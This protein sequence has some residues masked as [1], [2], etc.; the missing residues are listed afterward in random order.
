MS[1]HQNGSKMETEVTQGQADNTEPTGTTDAA[2]AGDEGQS[3]SPDRTT[4]SGPDQGAQGESFFDPKSIE[5]DPNLVA[6]YKGMQGTFSKKMDGIR[7]NQ[8][9]IDAYNQYIADPMGTVR[10]I[11]AQNGMTLVNGQP[12][13]TG[14]EE[15]SP[16]SWADVVSHVTDQVRAE[17]TQQYEPLVGEVKNLKQQNIEQYLDNKYSDW[18]TYESEMIG[19]LQAH[20]SMAHDPDKLYQMSLPPEVLEAR[21]TERAL[22]KLKGSTD[23]AM[24][25][26][27]K[28]ATQTTSD[29]PTGSLS[30]DDAVKFA[31]GQLASQGIT[32]PVGS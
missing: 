1:R 8:Q 11:A 16:Q 23:A 13:Q 7:D 22:K 6:A 20:P 32:G 31:K 10:Q 21:A 29:R 26:G 25:P 14:G 19:V 28:R 3:I 18:K 9:K 30:F 2:P 4:A 17:M 15:F 5:H 12:E 24:V 27:T